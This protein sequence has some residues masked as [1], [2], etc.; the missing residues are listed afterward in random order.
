MKRKNF[1]FFLTLFFFLTS[2]LFGENLVHYPLKTR[3]IIN[4]KSGTSDKQTIEKTLS[5]TLKPSLFDLEILYTKGPHHATELS[6]EAALLGYDLVIAVGGDGTV[7]EVGKGLLNSHTALA[8]VPAGSGNGFA[9]H[10][11]IP[12]NPSQAIQII[13]TFHVAKIDTVQI[14]DDYFLG[15]AGIGF[16]ANIAWNFAKSKQRG[17]WSYVSNVLTSYPQYSPQI[18]DMEIDGKKISKSGLLVSFA[19]SSQYGNDIHIAPHASLTDGH[20]HMVI[21]KNPPFY[22]LLD[23]LLKLRN[24]TITHS[25]YYES[26]CCREVKIEKKP[27]IGHIDGEPVYFEKG[28]HLKILPKSLTVV[29]PKHEHKFTSSAKK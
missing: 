4:P 9:K 22:A 26:I 27:L 12:Q 13:K 24:G 14:N 5:L 10:L 1:G 2:F 8:I 17:F 23:I 7:N 28:I 18:F 20:F 6:Q 21:L 16:D 3:V 19:K 25:K 11:G 29:I 15:V